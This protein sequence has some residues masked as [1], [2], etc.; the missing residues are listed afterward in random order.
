MWQIEELKRAEQRLKQLAKSF[1][2]KADLG[3]ER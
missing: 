1:E 2:R 3:S